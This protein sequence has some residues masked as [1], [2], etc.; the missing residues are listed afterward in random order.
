[1]TICIY[2]YAGHQ[3]ALP[4]RDISSI[5]VDGT[6]RAKI[7]HIYP[8]DVTNYQMELDVNKT[9]YFGI[10]SGSQVTTV[11]LPAPDDLYPD[12]SVGQTIDFGVLYNVSGGD[13]TV[14]WT[15]TG[16]YNYS[17]TD[18]SYVSGFTLST[19]SSVALVFE[20]G[21]DSN[22]GRTINWFA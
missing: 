17:A 14:S 15:T 21:V 9:K 13:I 8:D 18:P 1:M 20:I 2:V 19:D 22:G 4:T 5:H 12:K 16:T 3:S 6:F 10:V 11:T 7:E